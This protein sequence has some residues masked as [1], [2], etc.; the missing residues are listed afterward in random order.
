[1]PTQI[2]LQQGQKT[3][4]TT[5]TFVEPIYIIARDNAGNA[6]AT[7]NPIT[8][9]PGI[10]DS[11]RLDAPAWVGGNS[12]ASLTATLMDEFGNGV[13]GQEMVFTRLTGTGTLTRLDSLT[14]GDGSARADFLSPRFPEMDR[15]R[16]SSSGVVSE[17]NLETAFVDPYAPGGHVTNYP[18]P[19]H[20]P[21]ELTTIAYKLRDDATVTLRIFTLSGDLVLRRIYDRSTP[22]GLAGLNEVTWDGRNGE[23]R[24]VASGGYIVLIEAQGIGETLH[25]I[26]RKIA[27]VR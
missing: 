16:A 8:I 4:S 21:D 9:T 12:H 20:P 6:P 11:I 1:V 23:K 7:S 3:V 5:Y 2:Q 27:V 26:R 17:I 14:V 22:G 24:V 19:F 15:I 10:P 25:V 18:N 13:P